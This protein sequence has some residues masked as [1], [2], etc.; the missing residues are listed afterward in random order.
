MGGEFRRRQ[1]L[2]AVGSNRPPGA[3]TS[4]G[5]DHDIS[6]LAARQHGNVTYRKM[7]A[8]GCSQKAIRSRVEAGRLHR[9]HRGVYAV[10]RPPVMPLERAAAAVLA[11]GH[12]AALA[13]R[14]GLSLWDLRT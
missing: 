14:S 11:C 4:Q 6:A 9:V 8:L 1:P 13:H 7:L 10:G 5:P 2:K 3:R 12:N